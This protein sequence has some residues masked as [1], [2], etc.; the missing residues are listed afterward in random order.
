L[1]GINGTSGGETTGKSGT[2]NGFA[3]GMV[4]GGDMFFVEGK[5]AN[6]L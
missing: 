1:L 3:Q 5:H 4:E 6:V 2:K